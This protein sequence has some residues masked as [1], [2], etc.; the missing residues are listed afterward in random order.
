MSRFLKVKAT[1]GRTLIA[2]D[3]ISHIREDDDCCVITIK[4]TSEDI[5]VK[6]GY[7]SLV[8]RLTKGED[9]SAE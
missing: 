3:S 2:V 7:Q 6:D 1:S 9:T 4:H 8:N 5:E